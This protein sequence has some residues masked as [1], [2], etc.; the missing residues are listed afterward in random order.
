MG[1]IIVFLIIIGIL[2]WEINIFYKKSKTDIE[3]GLIILYAII[4]FTPILIYYLDLLNIPSKLFFTQNIDT[5]NW[6]AFLANYSSSIVAAIIGAVVSV[7]VM[8]YQINKNNEDI[9]KRDKENLRIQ[10]MPILKYSLDTNKEI[11]LIPENFLETNVDTLTT[12]S[13]AINIKNIGLNSIKS[14][15]VFWKIKELDV[16]EQVLGK[17]SV[18]VLE[19]EKEICVEKYFKLKCENDVYKFEL[20]VE[21]EDLLENKYIQ[22]VNVCYETTTYGNNGRYIGLEKHYVEKE[23]SL[24]KE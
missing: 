24:I 17:R 13:L 3:I 1:S 6:L 22:K 16:V 10:N 2:I 5:Q 21:Y 8:I 7:Y 14:I 18:E 19:K 11:E 12:Y 15:K 9:E 23:E 20:T 4:V